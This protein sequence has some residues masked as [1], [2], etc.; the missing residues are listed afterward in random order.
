VSDIVSAV[1][2]DGGL[3][4]GEIAGIAVGSAVGVL[5]L[6]ACSFFVGRKCAS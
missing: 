1:T 5:L 4:A 2:D 3:S 6:M